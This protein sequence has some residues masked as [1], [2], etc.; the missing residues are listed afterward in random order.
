MISFTSLD[1]EKLSVVTEHCTTLLQLVEENDCVQNLD[2]I[3]IVKRLNI[4][5]TIIKNNTVNT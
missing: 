1:D 4:P 5:I 2:M 3:I